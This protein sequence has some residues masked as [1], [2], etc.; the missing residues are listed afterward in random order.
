[1]ALRSR[2]FVVACALAVVGIFVSQPPVK[3]QSEQRVVTLAADTIDKVRAWDQQVDRMVRDRTLLRRQLI[4]DTLLPGRQH[5]RLDQYDRGVRVHGGDLTRQFD[6]GATVSLFGT[7]YEGMTLEPSPRLSVDEARDAIARAAGQEPPRDMMPELIVLPDA[8]GSYRLAYLGHAASGIDMRS[9]FID[10]NTGDLIR[11]HSD[12]QYQVI[13][14]GR[15]VFNDDKKVSARQAP[16]LFLADDKLRPGAITTYDMRGDFTRTLNVLNRVISVA[17]ADIAAD[18]DNDWTDGPNV[19]A[20]AYAGWYYD[21]LFKRFGRRGVDDNNLRSAVFVHPVRLE[22]IRTAPA[23]VVGQ[24]Y[25]NAFYCATCGPDG[26]G[27]VLFG[28]GAPI[29][30]PIAGVR[31]NNFAGELDVV[32]HELTHAVTFHTSQLRGPGEGGSLNEAFSDIIGAAVELFYQPRGIG[33]LRSEYVT[34]EDLTSPSRLPG[35]ARSLENPT[36]TGNPDHYSRRNFA[37]GI[38]FNSTIIGH[39]FYLAIEGG[40]NRTSGLTV[41]GV[42]A[43]N[44]EQIEKAFFRGFTVLMPSAG[45][46]ALARVTTMQAA[47]D[48][49]G[50]GSAVERAVTEAW[51]AVGVQ[52]RTVPSVTFTPNP[53]L[54]LPGASCSPSLATPNWVV[55]ATLSAAANAIIVNRLTINFLDEARSTL[56]TSVLTGPSFATLFSAC[57]APSARVPPQADACTQ[58]CVTLGGRPRGFLSFVFDAVDDAG[59]PFTV[60][61][62]PLPLL[63]AILLPLPL[64]TPPPFG[65][66]QLT[67]FA[68]P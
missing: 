29:G 12:I 30:F 25:V 53:A 9:Y 59:R 67:V 23:A 58:I 19:D 26:R 42:G 27:T 22:D 17:D 10:G 20:H 14:K 18:S 47:R 50:A 32:A 21:Y 16:S 51:N 15:G 68:E 5:E 49:Y 57:G 39:A 63:S 33:P 11:S 35:L 62:E 60:T 1:M 56:N 54:A 3:G 44:R 37:R 6:R 55:G 36:D 31:I 24:F 4:D 13:G 34:G 8:D 48:L 64:Q 45:T 66:A 43:N 65:P 52:E 41:A 28:E 40:T 61:S 46:F 7:L 2:A 38:H